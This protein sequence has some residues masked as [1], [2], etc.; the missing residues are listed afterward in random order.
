V[1]VGQLNAKHR[2]GKSFDY[3]ALDL[4]DTVFFGHNSLSLMYWLLVVRGLWQLDTPT[5]A[6]LDTKD[7]SYAM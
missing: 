4:D 1:A 6:V 3:C 5:K 7:L 2:I